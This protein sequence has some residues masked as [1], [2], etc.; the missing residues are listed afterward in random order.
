MRKSISLLAGLLL[1]LLL[2]LPSGQASAEARVFDL[3]NPDP[4]AV[5]HVLQTTYG[6]KVRAELIQQRLVVVGS[7]KQLDEVGELLRQLDRPPV[8]LHLTLR[9]TPP[10]AIEKDGTVVYSSGDDGYSLD[11][12]EGALVA[13]DYQ[14]IAQQ[15]VANGWLI[16]I[17]NQPQLVSSLTLQIQLRNNR[18]AGVLVSFADEKN[19]QRRVYANTLTGEVGAWIPLLPQQTEA[20]EGKG[21]YSSGTKKGQQLYLRIEKR[22]K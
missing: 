2:T 5:L 6:D 18:E 14:R 17:D 16:A 15:P 8:P 4:E 21:S 12:T 3:T 9:E 13:I 20:L 11:T 1:T 22:S 10:P 19:Q 7:K